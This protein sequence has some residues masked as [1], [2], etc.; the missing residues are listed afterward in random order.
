MTFTTDNI[1]ALEARPLP[2]GGWE[3]AFRSPHAGCHQLYLDGRLADW[4]ETPAAR[5]FFV[6]PSA[7][8]REAIVAAVAEADRATDFSALLPLP[9]RQ[10]PWLFSLEIT[11]DTRCRPGARL[12]LYDDGTEG[13]LADRPI[14]ACDL[15]PPSRPRWAWGEDFFGQGG[16]GFDGKAA[17]GFGGAPLG[18]GPMGLG[19]ELLRVALPLHREGRHRLRLRTVAPDGSAAETARDVL[20]TP[21]PPPAQALEALAYDDA[22]QTLTLQ[23]TRGEP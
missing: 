15:W 23:I 3:I 10:L 11:P 21:P 20:A 4:T 16:F 18:A 14:A 13:R 6:P 17:P 1:D 22:A 5:R 2:G 19:A 7:A 8:P 12:E 9:F